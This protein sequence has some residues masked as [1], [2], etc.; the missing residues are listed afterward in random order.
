M[1]IERTEDKRQQDE[2]EEKILGLEQDEK[3]SINK[4]KEYVTKAKVKQTK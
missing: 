4:L 3:V 1:A 2:L